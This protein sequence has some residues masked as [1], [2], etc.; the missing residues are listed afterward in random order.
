MTSRTTSCFSAMGSIST[1]SDFPQPWCGQLYDTALQVLV[2]NG[3]LAL[4]SPI[5]TLVK[6][7]LQCG[8]T[9][10]ALSLS[11]LRGVEIAS[12]RQGEAF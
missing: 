4:T 10:M 2:P 7:L 6:L 5:E 11:V 8:H 3:T 12:Y 9:L 1:P